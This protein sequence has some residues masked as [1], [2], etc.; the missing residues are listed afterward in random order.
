M[1]SMPMHWYLIL[2]V[3]IYAVWAWTIVAQPFAH[4][5]Y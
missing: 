5:P 2:I 3:A 1:P 4:H